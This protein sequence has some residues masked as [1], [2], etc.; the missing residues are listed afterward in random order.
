MGY[1]IE[2][3]FLIDRSKLSNRYDGERISQGYFNPSEVPTT[4][5]RVKGDKGYLTVKGK[6]EGIVRP[7]FEYEIPVGDAEYMLD[8]F[9]E[10]KLEKNRFIVPFAGKDWEVDVFL[11]DNEGL[12]IAEIELLSEDEKFEKPDW[13]AEEVSD[14]PKYYNSNLIEHPYSKWS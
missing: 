5:V 1:E 2:R 8:H 9:C 10:K 12:F 4:R 7:E 14:D 11:G 13:V 3:K 6:T